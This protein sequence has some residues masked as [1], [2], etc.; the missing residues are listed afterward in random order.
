MTKSTNN[1]IRGIIAFFV[2]MFILICIISATESKWGDV[3]LYGALS[4]VGILINIKLDLQSRNRA[5]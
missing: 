4:I 3:A 5:E 2:M 1:T